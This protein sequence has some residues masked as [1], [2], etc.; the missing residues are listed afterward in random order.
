M[1]NPSTKLSTTVFSVC[2]IG[3]TL[4]GCGS[5][6][7][8]IIS[9]PSSC[10]SGTP[11]TNVQIP[12]LI[13]SDAALGP[14]LAFETNLNSVTLTDSCGN[15]VMLLPKNPINV[16]WSHVNGTSEPLLI[17]TVPEA[18]YTSAQLTYSN[19]AIEYIYP[20]A[21]NFVSSAVVSDATTA[22]VD[23][24]D[25][26]VVDGNGTAIVLDALLAQ[27]IVIDGNLDKVSPAFRITGVNVIANPV[28]DN[29]GKENLRGLVSSV[30]SGQFTMG[31]SAGIPLIININA[32]TNFQGISG[33]STLPVHQP[34]DVDVTIQKDGSLLATRIEAEIVAPNAWAGLKV[35]PYTQSAFEEIAPRLWEESGDP[36]HVY[37]NPPFA[38]EFNQN[39]R[40]S[41]TGESIDLS[42]L[43]FTP[44]FASAGDTAL[45]QGIA[46]GW[47]SLAS[48]TQAA[49]ITLIPRT[50]SGTVTSISNKGTYMVYE[51][52]LASNDFLT[53]LNGT[54]T[55]TAYTNNGT[56]AENLSPITAG[57][58]VNFHG[59]L[60]NDNGILRLVC[61]QVRLQIAPLGG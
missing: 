17:A 34:A 21:N 9:P 32:N 53:V 59:L 26:I 20:Q 12:V 30:S 10:Q 39:T 45:G 3:I 6:T 58:P 29:N 19:P 56:Q 14:L 18:T 23:F 7:Q 44:R 52:A 15:K 49:T 55:I 31:N 51:L 2:A 8:R 1:L 54:S 24:P 22:H 4:A 42:D 5:G 47:G 36:S 16:E 40:Y 28:N 38:Y 37:N 61:D 41:I 13:A 43:P 33:L 27:P 11:K 57:S 35:G 25:P 60:F 46:V 50:V 48:P